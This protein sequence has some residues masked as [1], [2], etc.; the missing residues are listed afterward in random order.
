MTAPS[1]QPRSASTL[2]GVV[3]IAAYPL[4]TKPVLRE[5]SCHADW[6]ARVMLGEVE[7]RSISR[8]GRLRH[9]S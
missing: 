6:V 5:F 7:Y 8:D 3:T 1:A 4:L 2:C 9:P